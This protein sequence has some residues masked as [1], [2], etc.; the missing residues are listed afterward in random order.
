MAIRRI[1]RFPD[2]LLRQ[3]T[4][5]VREVD[6]RIRTLVEDMMDTMYAAEGAGLAAIQIGAPERIFIVESEVAGRGK[7][8]PVV[9]INPVI[10]WLSHETEVKDEGCLSFPGIFIP[11]KRSLVARVSALDLDGRPFMA[12]GSDLYARA[13]QHEHDHL[14]GKLLYD[15]A[16]PV[17]RQVIKRKLERMTDEEAAALIARHGD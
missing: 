8:A 15:Y 14:I 9:F 13:M 6:A 5:E 1:I 10:E 7:E 2:P 17:K 16:G 11:V 12:E 3:T 4:V